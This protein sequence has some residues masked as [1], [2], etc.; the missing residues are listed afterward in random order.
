MYALVVYESMAGNAARAI[1]EAVARGLADG[2]RAEVAE[3]ASAPATIGEDVGLLV[4]GAPAYA[5]W[6]SGASTRRSAARQAGG[7]SPGVQGCGV[8]EWLGVLRTSS[9]SL[10]AVAFDVRVARPRLP[11][12][13]ARGVI[14]R[15]RRAGVRPAGPAWSFYVTGTRGR[16]V[17]GELGRA[18]E[19]GQSLAAS[20]AVRVP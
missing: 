10:E 2:M 1:A 17:A 9:A 4:V 12:S 11:G 13:A 19:W 14:R 18:R 20:H 16:L 6:M 15:L 8:R 7:A 3:A 5:F